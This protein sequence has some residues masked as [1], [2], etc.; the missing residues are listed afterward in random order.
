MRELIQFNYLSYIAR[1]QANMNTTSSI[2]VV[3]V[4]ASLLAGC[5]ESAD[6]SKS[7]VLATVKRLFEEREFGI[8]FKMPPGIILVQEKSATYLSSDKQTN[9]ARCSVI[10]TVDLIQ[11]LKATQPV[12]DEQVARMKRTGQ[13]TSKDTLVNYTVQTLASGESY[14]TV[15]P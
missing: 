7:D 15:L 6:C 14:I 13:E 1:D 10:V 5:G 12:T 8:G 2:A 4:V 3:V 9:T 11:L